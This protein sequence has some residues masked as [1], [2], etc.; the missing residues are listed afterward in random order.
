M[1]VWFYIYAH[2]QCTLTSQTC[3]IPFFQSSVSAEA[4]LT[5]TVPLSST[6][7]PISLRADQLGHPRYAVTH[8]SMSQHAWPCPFSGI[9]CTLEQ[10]RRNNPLSLEPKGKR[11]KTC[12]ESLSIALSTSGHF[13]RAQADPMTV[14]ESAQVRKQICSAGFT[15]CKTPPLQG[16]KSQE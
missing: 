6:K 4:A 9:V 7:W 10:V 12:F 3:S 16:L 13:M 2:S 14:R 11:G 8:D 1:N 15:A 5:P